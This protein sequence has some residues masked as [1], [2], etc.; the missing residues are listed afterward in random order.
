MHRTFFALVL[1]VSVT[2][3]M[4]L[5]C[6]QAGTP[7]PDPTDE[8]SD[9]AITVAPI[10]GT[11]SASERSISVDDTD[12]DWLLIAFAP[13]VTGVVDNNGT[14][15]DGD[16][17][18]VPYLGETIT[19][20]VTQDAD[21]GTVTYEGTITGNSGGFKMVF[22]TETDTFDYE[23]Y[24]ILRDTV[25]PQ[26]FFFFQLMN[27]VQLDENNYYHAPFDLAFQQSGGAGGN[28]VRTTGDY[29]YGIG[30]NSKQVSGWA[31]WSEWTEYNGDAFDG[32]AQFPLPPDYSKLDQYLSAIE[33]TA[34]WITYPWTNGLYVYM[35]DGVITPADGATQPHLYRMDS[36]GSAQDALDELDAAIPWTTLLGQ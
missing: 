1:F 23:Q 33:D 13:L 30:E 32:T 27:D 11:G 12:S 8:P 35:E 20:T 34:N 2:G 31:T 5:S 18:T 25:S 36:S 3:A 28:F 22:Y 19:V 24:V 14:Y 17:F 6:E 9:P 7:A 29:F 10:I 4:L 21:A 26:D 15:S 16:S